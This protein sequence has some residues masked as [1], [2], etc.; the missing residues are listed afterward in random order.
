[1]AS[2]AEA[3][4]CLFARSD[5]TCSQYRADNLLN[6][7]RWRGTTSGS[8]FNLKCLFQGRLLSSPEP[9]MRA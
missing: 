8:I 9:S 7:T 5:S 2:Q 4:P 3:M 1:M 6:D